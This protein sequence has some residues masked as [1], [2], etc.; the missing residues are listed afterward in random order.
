VIRRLS[1]LV[2]AVVPVA[3]A[4]C[5][6]SGG[7]AAAASPGGGST[8]TSASSAP[9]TLRLGYFPNLTHAPALVGV[10]KGIF[11]KDLGSNVTL[12]T[13]T[14]NAG[15]AEVEAIFSGALDAGFMGPNPATTAFQ[16]SKGQAV[17]V[18]SG[19][20]SGGAGLVVR[21]GI[22]SASQLK[23]KTLATPQL[24]NTQDVALRHWLA[25]EGLTSTTSGGGDVAIV[26]EDNSQT[27]LAFQAGQIDGAWVPEPYLSTLVQAGG[28]LLVDERT[29]WPHQ[30][31]STTLL[32]VRTA[33]L[34][35]HPDVVRRLLVGEVDT[36]SYIKAH[37][38]DA[39]A[40]ANQALAGISGKTLKPAV[41][42]AAWSDLS[43]TL[44]PVVSSLVADAQR[45]QQLG[46]LKSAGVKGL[47]DL[48]PLD[49]I[50]RGRGE[51]A[52]SGS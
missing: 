21:S 27:V 47:F 13:P 45:A 1:L 51:T 46:F 33:F 34:D 30:Q 12:Q 37:P 2:L 8:T 29:L 9:V 50:L 19:A 10:Q 23:G 7:G 3:A 25:T 41:L 49:S 48:G 18:I 17:R 36:I 6:S 43:F 31:F 35:A 20:T 40:A 4:A 32:V 28:K 39:Q 24:G 5:G 38:A 26:P 42:T 44:D 16:Q 14:F 11:A 52:V 22:T 15:P